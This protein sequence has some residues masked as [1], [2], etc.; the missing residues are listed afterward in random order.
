[1]MQ[2]INEYLKS[3]SHLFYPELC[4]SCQMNDREIEDAFCFECY[5]ELPFTN[6]A[7]IPENEFMEHFKGKIKI[8]HGSALFY[9]IKKGSIQDIIFQFK[10]LNKIKYGIILGKI[11]GKVIQQSKYY[12]SI[13]AIVPIPL[14]AKKQ[15][16]RGFN[17]S[18]I[19]ARGISKQLFIPIIKNNIIRKKNTSTQTKMNREDRL[20]N[21]KNAFYM[22]D[23]M[24]FQG[25]HILL[26]DDVLTTGSTLLEC[27]SQLKN[28]KGI[29][30][31]MAT[32]AMGEPV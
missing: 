3:F 28:I 17:Q 19:L 27:A 5:S 8:E 21:L 14:H 30:I 22:K 1:M 32:I 20:N 16:L 31:S 9:F 6:Q 24:I 25:K 18:E 4:I 2:I 10:Y 29:K 11:F 13:D 7:N 23:P 12:N 26:L 15:K